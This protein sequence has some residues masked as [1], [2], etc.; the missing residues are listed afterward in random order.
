MMFA[1]YSFTAPGWTGVGMT[2]A[3]VAVLARHIVAPRQH[4]GSGPRA[5]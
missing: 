1:F 4:G 3:A 2:A 5:A